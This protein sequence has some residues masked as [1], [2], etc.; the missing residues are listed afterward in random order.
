MVTTRLKALIRQT[1]ILSRQDRPCPICHR[2]QRADEY[3]THLVCCLTKPRIQYNIDTLDD[4]FGECLICYE[5]L[6]T[7]QEIAR[8]PCLCIYHIK[9][10][11]DW[12]K[13]KG[14]GVFITVARSSIKT[15]SFQR[16]VRSIRRTEVDCF[17]CVCV[18]VMWFKKHILQTK[19]S[20]NSPS[21]RFCKQRP[22]THIPF[23]THKASISI[24]L[25][26][27]LT[28]WRRENYTRIEFIR[29]KW[30][31]YT[32]MLANLTF[33]FNFLK[34]N[35]AKWPTPTHTRYSLDAEPATRY[36]LHS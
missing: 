29:R 34:K 19:C 5:D 33:V 17:C 4:N 10:L 3:E 24:Y 15:S 23:K 26:I 20:F 9:C 7:G 13:V 31:V 21:K 36:A 14:K 22:K 11:Q 32:T 28:S 8:L 30:H 18:C 16:N 25:Y 2:V 27:P 12:F 35:C 1:I 6:D